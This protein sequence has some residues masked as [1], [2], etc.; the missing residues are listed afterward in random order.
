MRC[1]GAFLAFLDATDRQHRLPRHLALLRG[2]GRRRS[3]LGAR[4][5][6]RRYRGTAG[7]RGRPRRPLRPRGSSCSASPASPP[8]ACSAPPLPR[9]GLLIAF[10]VVQGIGAAM[11]AP[12]SLALVLDSV[13]NRAPRRRSRHLGC[14]RRGGSRGGPD[15]RGSAGGALG[16][17]PR[18][19]GQPAVGG[20]RCAG[21]PRGAA[22]AA[23]TRQSAARPSRRVDARLEPGAWSPSASSRATIGA[24]PR[25]PRSE[26][27]PRPR[28]FSAEWSR[29]ASATH[30]QSSS[31][32]CS[33]TALSASAISAPSSSPPPSSR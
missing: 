24:G 8:R 32:R 25:P 19:P 17:A 12:T 9:I 1:A 10:R 27:S 14:C 29:A 23:A 18:L 7:P 30:A 5:L 6:L 31:Q 11:I 16:L 28:L 4:R 2:F 21:R 22:R 13:P 20:C 3:V 33:A 26:P 15:L